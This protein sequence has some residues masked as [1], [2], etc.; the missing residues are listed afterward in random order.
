MKDKMGQEFI[1][2]TCSKVIK[3]DEHGQSDDQPLYIN[4]VGG[5]GDMVDTVFHENELIPFCHKCG[6]RIL[7]L[8]GRN[9]IDYVNP[10][11]TT[12]HVRPYKA[13]KGKKEVVSWWHFGWDNVTLRGYIS[14]CF[15][16]FRL[17]G[18][19]GVPYA[20]KEVFENEN[21]R[22]LLNKSTRSS[23]F[24]ILTIAKIKLPKWYSVII[25]KKYEG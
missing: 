5:Y 1:C 11:N 14:A 4:V 7:R 13:F 25:A 15:H 6:H 2:C 20:F 21:E 22:E 8:M 17:L 9:I 10:I 18:F 24:P 12:S 3:L 19:K 16:Y 23:D